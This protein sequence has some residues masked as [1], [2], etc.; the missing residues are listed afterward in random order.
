MK[1]L[2]KL[3]MAFKNTDIVHFTSVQTYSEAF[4]SISTL[5]SESEDG[6]EFGEG[7]VPDCWRGGNCFFLF[8]NWLLCMNSSI[9]MLSSLHNLLDTRCAVTRTNTDRCIQCSTQI[10]LTGL[11]MGPKTVCLLPRPQLPLSA[12]TG[13]KFSVPQQHLCGNQK[14]NFSVHPQSTNHFSGIHPSAQC[15]LND[16]NFFPPKTV[17]TC[18]YICSW[19][20]RVW[21]SNQA[22]TA[23]CLFSRMSAQIWQFN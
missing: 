21:K 8:L 10:S 14:G 13:S 23:T 22:A 15:V 12:W 2:W 18:S 7:C 5:R 16:H 17:P 6:A 19:W 11:H 9:I 1:V 20:P 4:W 3:F